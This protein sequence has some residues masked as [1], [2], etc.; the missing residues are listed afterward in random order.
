MMHDDDDDDVEDKSLSQETKRR[1]G[2]LLWIKVAG[3]S[4][5]SGVDSH[6]CRGFGNGNLK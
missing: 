4:R 3:T 5:P 2:R 1:H 6:V